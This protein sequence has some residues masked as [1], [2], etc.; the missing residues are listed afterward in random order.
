MAT[1]PKSI[2]DIGSFKTS[3]KGGLRANRY[4]IN[5]PFPKKISEGGPK[6]V[7]SFLVKA[8]SFPESTL[9]VITIPWRG[10]NIRLPGDRD[11]AA[12]TFTML[13][14]SDEKTGVRRMFEKWNEL[15]NEH[16][17]NAAP[18]SATSGFVPADDE[19][20]TDWSINFLDLKG[21]EVPNRAVK[22]HNCW[23]VTVAP[24]PVSFEATNT[25]V[26]YDVTFIYDYITFDV[27]TGN[28][29]SDSDS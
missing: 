14:D 9:G 17:S 15:F 23:P 29:K 5:G 12:W 19:H 2:F 21:E 13:D 18:K 16:A 7:P 20:V 22:L 1:N 26:E 6:Q 11:Y 8:A 4:K 24:I 3:F 27:N 28:A 10:R 25:L